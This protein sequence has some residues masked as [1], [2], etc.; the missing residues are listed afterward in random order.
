MAAE[1]EIR[2]LATKEDLFR[3]A[4]EEF[5][6]QALAAVKTRGKF[7]VA[8][9]GGSTPKGMYGLL[10]GSAY[11]SLPWKQIF[12]FWGDERHVPPGHSDSNY[13]MVNEVLLSKIPLPP[14]N[15]FR[16]MAEK[17]ADDAA[18]E[19]EQTLLKFFNLGPGQFP[20]F[21]LVLLGIGTEGH[22]ASLFPDSSALLEKN[23][24]VVPNW[25]EKLKTHRITLTLPVLNH[26]ACVTF[27]IGGK[28][29]AEIV[30]EVL[31]GVK[32]PAALVRPDDGRLLWLL[33]RDA[34]G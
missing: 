27:L 5:A 3:N 33:D 19:Y 7:T 9:S 6:A 31:N 1:R 4:A 29:K 8:L 2:V 12:F 11:A 22:I 15:I 24:L 32:V 21:D 26:A 16:I 30:R 13:R 23:R 10:A 20:R 14:E 28:D 34:A 18:R 25:V 17:D